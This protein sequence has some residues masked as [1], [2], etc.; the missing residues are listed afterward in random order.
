LMLWGLM[1]ENDDFIALGKVLGELRGGGGFGGL[2][3]QF[4]PA[5][6]ES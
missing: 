1:S 3:R 4:T 5:T 6:A 2:R